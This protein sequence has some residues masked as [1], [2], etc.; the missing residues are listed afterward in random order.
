MPIILECTS[1][2]A[3]FR[4]PPWGTSHIM[5]LFREHQWIKCLHEEGKCFHCE[6]PDHM[7]KDCPQQH[8]KKPP[9]RL[10]SVMMS[11][12]EIKLAALSEGKEMSLFI[13]GNETHIIEYQSSEQS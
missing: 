8:N 10:H 5:K 4:F 6:S 1:V 7:A 2:R 12:T 11:A 13:I 9:M 3:I